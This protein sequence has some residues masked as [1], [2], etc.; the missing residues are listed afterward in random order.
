[1]MLCAAQV[2]NVNLNGE[3]GHVIGPGD[4]ESG[5][6]IGDEKRG[7]VIGHGGD[8]RGHVI[9]ELLATEQNFLESLHVVRDVFVRPLADSKL[10]DPSE[11][12]RDFMNLHFGRKVFGQTFIPGANPTAFEFTATTPALL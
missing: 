10:A 4:G 12:V 2:R 3:R 6:V 11:L 5:H 8:K 1:M 9:G 7:Q